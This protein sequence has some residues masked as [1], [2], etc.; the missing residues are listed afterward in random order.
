[1]N[2][3]EKLGMCPSYK[4]Y[5]YWKMAVKIAKKEKFHMQRIYSKIAEEFNTTPA[6][7]H[8][9][10]GTSL[11]SITNIEKKM[12]VDYDVTQKKFLA[13]LVYKGVE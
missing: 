10:M 1:M 12:K 7:I 5:E 13:W 3:L 11:N 9:G 2:K 8:R 6:A 4:G